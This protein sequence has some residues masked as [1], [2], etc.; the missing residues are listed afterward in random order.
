MDGKG[1]L[2]I[3]RMDRMPNV[4]VR[5]LCGMRMR[6]DEKIDESVLRWFGNNERI[7]CYKSIWGGVSLGSIVCGSRGLRSCNSCFM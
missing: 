2:G 5:N 7:D 3:R 4:R 6:V 1:K